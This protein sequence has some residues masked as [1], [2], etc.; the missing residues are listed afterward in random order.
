LRGPLRPRRNVKL[1]D[2]TDSPNTP[3]A[4]PAP[5]TDAPPEIGPL[6]SGPQIAVATLIGTPVAGAILASMNFARLGKRKA[7]PVAL[8]LAIGAIAIALVLDAVW[9]SA[10]L[11][12]AVPLWTFAAFAL[13]AD[14]FHVSER[15][16]AALVFVVPVVVVIALIGVTRVVHIYAPD[17]V[18]SVAELA[19]DKMG[20]QGG[21]I[22]YEDR[23]AALKVRNALDKA[24]LLSGEYQVAF[25]VTR[26][27]GQ[28]VV[29]I[30]LPSLDD[31]ALNAVKSFSRAIVDNMD[32][33]ECIIAKVK[34]PQR[35]AEGKVCP[36]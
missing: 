24:G 21:Q 28:I 1:G 4:L 9:S 2:V 35:S 23:E 13:T 32:Q 12:L 14:R 11:F 34:S 7:I 25:D 30:E 17:A 3:G 33:P 6:F 8:A 27:N 29:V 5:P 26:E 15:R 18:P 22:R 19:F 10:A 31:K 16:G 36:R 20:V